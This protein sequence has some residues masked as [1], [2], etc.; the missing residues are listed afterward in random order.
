MDPTPLPL[1]RIREIEKAG[2]K[3]GLPLMQRAGNAIADVVHRRIRPS[4]DVLMLVGP[5]NNGGDA[6]VAA[7]ALK[8]AGYA[9]IVWMPVET[10][11]PPDAEE[12][13]QAWRHAGGEVTDK[14][15]QYK[16]AFVVDGLFGIGL[17]RPIGS[18][19]QEAIDTINQWNIPVLAVDI[20]SGLE[21]DTG[22]HL[23]RP[24]RATWT[25]SF[26]APTQALFSQSGKPMA[27]E[28]MIERLGLSASA[29]SASGCTSGAAR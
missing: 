25:V 28:I 16:P 18:P 8:Q 22:K 20:P 14:L 27:G 21:A 13:R 7:L 4:G 24:V 26:I 12:A 19:W 17:N 15:P 23:G 11:L 10:N 1:S 3:A 9:I 5:G 2:I 6:L 29:Y